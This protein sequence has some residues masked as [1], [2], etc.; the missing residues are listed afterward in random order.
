MGSLGPGGPGAHSSGEIRRIRSESALVIEDQLSGSVAGAD[1]E[2]AERRREMAL[3]VAFGHK[4][5]LGDLSVGDVEYDHRKRP[6]ARAATAA[7]VAQFADRARDH[8]LP[9][10]NPSERRQERLLRSVRE[11]RAPRPGRWRRAR[12]RPWGAA[13]ATR[14]WARCGRPSGDRA[15]LP[16]DRR[17]RSSLR[18]RSPALRPRTPSGC[19]L[20]PTPAP[21]AIAPRVVQQPNRRLA[22][23]HVPAGSSSPRTGVV[24]ILPCDQLRGLTYGRHVV[25]HFEHGP[26]T[27][28][29]P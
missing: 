16:Q 18:F 15:G 14:R 10:R 5:L 20:A 12:H 8:A 13:R 9:G 27:G 26:P 4:Q 6:D 28:S 21:A 3:D 24:A 7:D 23:A 22:I 29:S 19:L 25:D 17:H 11:Y 1:S 2:L